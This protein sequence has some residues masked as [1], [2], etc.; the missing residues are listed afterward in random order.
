MFD[1]SPLS[2]I[3]NRIGKLDDLASLK[4]SVVI[5]FYNE[6]NVLTEC[7]ERLCSILN[8]I[9]GHCEIIYVDDGST[10]GSRKLVEQFSVSQISLKYIGLSRNF[11]KEAAMSAGLEQARGMAV[12][13]LDADL[14]DPPELILSM[15][16]K[17]E[18]GYDIVNMQRIKRN[19][20]TWFKRFSAKCFYR[21]L[22][23]LS[24]I[25]VPN[26]V[27]DFRL[28][29]R[30]VVDN[31][32]QMPEKN[33]YMKGIFSWPGFR[34]ITLPFVREPRFSGETKWNYFKL[35]GLA[36]DGITSFSIKP[37]RIATFLGCAIALFSFIYGVSIIIKTM[38]FSEVVSG[39]PSMMVVQ[40]ALGGIQL[41]CIGVMGEYIGRIFIETKNRPLYLIQTIIE[42]PAVQQSQSYEES[43]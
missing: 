3:S 25:D 19:G 6:E 14:Q 30:E 10:D 16:K 32:N 12:I 35:V 34:Q 2:L 4:L 23:T 13:L 1:S 21:V 26:N 43:A 11:G 42:Q 33:R 7:H 24:D 28:L 9:D 5:P 41:L 18:E 36:V 17:W 40:L 39:Y 20:E 27:G 15:V 29:S 8:K 37:L 38:I 31:I 22:N